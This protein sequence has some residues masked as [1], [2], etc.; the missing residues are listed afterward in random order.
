[1]AEEKTIDQSDIESISNLRDKF[2]MTTSRIGQVEVE[3]H[4]LNKRLEAIH[5]QRE[6]LFSDYEEAGS[7][8]E[9]LVKTLSEK[10]G[11]GTIDLDTGKFIASE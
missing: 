9:A 3:L 7:E 6:R 5:Q 8:E 2:A 1:M 11:D 10:Y 4:V